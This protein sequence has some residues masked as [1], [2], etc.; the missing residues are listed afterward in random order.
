MP[1]CFSFRLTEC[2]M[3]TEISAQPD[4]VIHRHRHH[5]HQF[6]KCNPHV[7]N[8]LQSAEISGIQLWWVICEQLNINILFWCTT[9]MLAYISASDSTSL[10][11]WC[12]ALFWSMMLADERYLLIEFSNEWIN[13]WRHVDQTRQSSVACNVHL[14]IHDTIWIS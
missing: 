13:R 2:E 4:D 14:H 10:L 9:S 7:I 6:F 11:H 8:D 12:R 5:R 3:T 1:E